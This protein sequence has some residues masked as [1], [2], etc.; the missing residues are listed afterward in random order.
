MSDKEGRWQA[1][2]DYSNTYNSTFKNPNRL[3][4]YNIE[5]DE[6]GD[7]EVAAFNIIRLRVFPNPNLPKVHQIMRNLP[8][9]CE[10]REGKK[11]LFQIANNV[12]PLLPNSECVDE[13]G[14]YLKPE[15]IEAKW[16]T[17]NQQEITN[18]LRKAVSP[19]S[20]LF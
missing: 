10:S 17:N 13:Q 12:D 9:Y 18:S 7:L 16:K 14:N 19:T 20:A 1:L 5:E 6:I 2:I 15:E 11:E 8:K 3:S 4:K